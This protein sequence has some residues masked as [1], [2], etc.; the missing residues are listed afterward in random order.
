MDSSPWLLSLRNYVKVVRRTWLRC[1]YRLLLLRYIKSNVPFIQ[2]SHR[3][4][5]P[6]GHLVIV[7]VTRNTARETRCIH[8]LN[9]Q[10]SHLLCDCGACSGH[11]KHTKCSPYSCQYI[12]WLRL[13]FWMWAEPSFA[14]LFFLKITWVY[15]N[16]LMWLLFVLESCN[17]GSCHEIPGC[18]DVPAVGCCLLSGRQWKTRSVGRISGQAAAEEAPVLRAVRLRQLDL[19]FNN[20]LRNP[21]VSKC[22]NDFNYVWTLLR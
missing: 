8:I 10:F 6:A 7:C 18:K 11:S 15:F 5:A 9:I 19:E 12:R 20:K 13:Q 3:K 21:I 1:K 4:P 22:L 16:F 14:V 2:T 17:Y